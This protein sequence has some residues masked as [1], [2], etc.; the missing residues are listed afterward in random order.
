MNKIYSFCAA[1]LIFILSSLH[2]TAQTTVYCSATGAAGSYTT[3]Y[4]TYATTTDGSALVNSSSVATSQQRAFAVFNLAAMNIPANATITGAVLSLHFSLSGTAF[5]PTVYGSASNYSTVNNAST[6]FGNIVAGTSLCTGAWGSVSSVNLSLNTATISLLQSNLTGLI[7]LG[8]ASSGTST[9]SIYTITGETGTGGS[10]TATAPTIAITYTCSASVAISANTGDTIC[11]GNPVVF[12]ST[13]TNGGTAPTYQWKK[14]GTSIS[15][16][17][18]ASY[19]TSSIS[20]ADIFTCLMT[21]NASCVTIPAITSNAAPMKVVSSAIPTITTSVSPGNSICAGSPATFSSLVVYG[22]GT[23]TYQWKKNSTNITGATGA[24]YTSSSI[25]NHDTIKC[26]VTSSLSC[27]SPTTATSSNITMAVTALSLPT[28]TISAGTGNTI[29]AG[30]SVTFS[31]TVTNGGT[32]PTYQWR[33]NGTAIT[34]ATSSTYATSAISNGDVFRCVITSNLFCATPAIDSSNSLTMIVNPT[35]LPTLSITSST[36]TAVCSGSPVTFS[37]TATNAGTAPT[38]QWRKNGTAITG[39]TAA[40]YTTSA[41]NNGDIFRCVI[42]SNAQC[43]SPAIDSS[44]SITMTVNANLVPTSSIAASTGNT[45]CAGSSA[46]FSNTVVNGGTAP[47]YQWMKNGTAITGATNNTY[48]STTLSNSDIITCNVT[49]SLPCPTPATVTSN[50]VTMTVNPIITPTIAI[51]SSLGDTI[52]SGNSVLFSSA[53]TNGGTSPSYVWKKNGAV[54]SGATSATYTTTTA[55]TGN[56]YSCVLTSSATCATVATSN[57]ATMT[58]ISA[59]TPGIIIS[60]SP[61]DTICN[62]GSVTFSSTITYGGAAPTYQWKKNGNVITGAT[63]STYTTSA[64]ASGDVFKCVLTSALSCAGPTTATSNSIT[65]TVFPVTAPTISIATNHGDSICTGHAIAFTSAIT[66]GGTSP[67]YQWL[68]NGNTI[69]G[70]NGATYNT[71]TAINGD[72]FSCVVTSSYLCSTPSSDTSNSITLL[73]KP[74]LTPTTSITVNPGTSIC[75]GDIATFNAN[76]T[77]GGNAPGYKW[78]KNGTAIAGGIYPTITVGSIANGDVIKC[79]LTSSEQCATPTTAGSNNISMQVNQN[80]AP[81]VDIIVNPG[82]NISAGT[83]VSFTAFPINGGTNPGYQWYSNG[84]PISSAT[85]GTYSTNNLSNGQK[86]SV[87]MTSNAQCSLPLSVTSSSDTISIIATGVQQVNGSSN[88]FVLYPNPT[89][90]AF[91]INAL[92]KG[93]LHLYSIS[94]QEMFEIAISEKT[95]TVNLPLEMAKG[96]YIA[97]FINSKGNASAI[98]RLI[99]Q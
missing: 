41:I 45:I 6:L 38:Y 82:T 63:S 24:T 99:Y 16:A 64:V 73:V 58:A 3:G 18:S 66:N 47:S 33:K 2:T 92:D 42:T 86:I 67:S 1:I 15:G 98:V 59:A 61:K 75:L 9:T 37:T 51:A 28:V 71:T 69:A 5:V 70:A 85:S 81:A 26:V 23:P 94:G 88:H 43:A 10:S 97:Q 27:A 89:N 19:T 68:K 35:V 50:N 12:S 32:T 87:K 39:A 91:T 20:N 49:S 80:V 8:F 52:C 36:G 53:I 56:I 83:N 74:L 55:V 31:S 79:V 46:S 29:C 44:N 25:N 95:S 14:N 13:A 78:Y 17:T 65:M 22:G 34:G 57:A 54:I 77:N 93:I 21:S 90:G 96:V 48:S 11:T 30:S 7:S 4:T 62:G 40:T 60:V 84:N 72:A 76:I